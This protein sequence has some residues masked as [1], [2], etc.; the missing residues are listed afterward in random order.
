[1]DTT[2]RS[3]QVFEIPIL[4]AVAAASLRST[5]LG[6]HVFLNST[7]SEYKNWV[8]CY[9]AGWFA[10]EDSKV[11]IAENKKHEV[12]GIALYEAVGATRVNGKQRATVYPAWP[13]SAN[14]T[15]W[16]S[17]QE[18]ICKLQAKAEKFENGY[19]RR[20]TTF[21]FPDRAH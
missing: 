10:N 21:P 7:G 8:T 9:V 11:L 5:I 1:M 16:K 14:E 13:P 3:A 12:C 4:A 20:Q 19:H 2:I 6:K 18:Q 15:L 17:V